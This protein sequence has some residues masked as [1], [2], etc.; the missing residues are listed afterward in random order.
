[1]TGDSR[2]R[3]FEPPLLTGDLPAAGGAVGPEPEDFV[4]DEIPLAAPSGSGEHLYVRIKKRLWTTP[5]MLHAVARAAKVRERD[6]GSAG[7]KDKRAVTSQWVSLP[8]GAASTEN[9]A[10]PEGLEVLEAQPSGRKLRT[11]QLRGN[12]F[13]IRLVGIDAAGYER[14]EAICARLRETGLPNYFGAQ[15]FGSGGNNLHEAMEWLARGASAEGRRGRF[16]KKLY[17]SVVQ[18][19]IF[20]RYL[21]LRSEAGLD[22]LLEGEVVRLDGSRSVFV[23]EDPEAE[24]PRLASGDIHLTGPIAGPRMKQPQGVP[25][26][27]E[28]RATSELGI[29]ARELELM[30]RIADGTRRDLVVDVEGLEV[31][32]ARDGSLV[33]RFSLPSGSYA[34]GVVRE[35]THAPFL[36]V[37]GAG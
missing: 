22:R 14:A 29:G 23:V 21:A 27:L 30:G 37:R 16:Y 25:Q 28:A 9:W 20:N 5:D 6:I 31:E 26:E 11:G 4:V 10:L 35:L 33:V 32:A 1:M 8:P 15:R 34:T 24:L 2:R 3:P 36:E 7:M 19:E 13:H 18:A 12:R 17:P